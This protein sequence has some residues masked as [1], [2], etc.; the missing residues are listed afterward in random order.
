[1]ARLE[2]GSTTQG[3]SVDTP[4][5]DVD[6][7][8]R[9]FFEAAEPLFQR[10]GFRKTTVE[11]VCRAAGVSKR[12]FYDLF[13]DKEDLLMQ[14][15]EAVCNGMA[16]AWEATLSAGMSPLD[17]LHGFLD[18][19]ARMVREHPFLAVLVEDLELMRSFGEKTEEIRVSQ[20]GG[21][22][23]GILRDG[24][25]A[26]QFRPLDPRAAL[27]VVFGLLDTVYLLMPK[28][29]NAPGPLEDPAL[30]EETKQFIV[31][32]LGAVEAARGDQ[33][34]FRKK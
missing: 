2:T 34:D 16:V 25:A 20:M 32:G 21:T 7:K 15:V 33:N 4:Y 10:F 14:L 18:F 9:R 31:R 28:V 5:G 29:M 12:T 22:L 30:A 26:G 8:R 27:W 24:V 1:M 3:S 23:D 19:Y 11:E 13:K 17:R 6:S